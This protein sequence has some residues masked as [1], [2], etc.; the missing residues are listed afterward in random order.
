MT[1][2]IR[3]GLFRVDF[4]LNSDRIAHVVYVTADRGDSEPTWIEF[5]RSIE[6]SPEVVWPDSPPLQELHVEARDERSVALLVGRAGKSHWS[7]S[8][9]SEAATV[10]SDDAADVLVFD[11]ACRVSGLPEMLGSTYELAEGVSWREN[12]SSNGRGT[13][14]S[15]ALM[16]GMSSE[17]RLDIDAPGIVSLEQNAG[18]MRIQAPTAELTLPATVRW[19]FTLA[20]LPA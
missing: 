13:G 16:V 19:R 6:S 4:L 8:I 18:R 15:I 2:T 3:S 11:I 9:G 14:C 5:M 20:H 1:R 17:W 12:G 10:G 7:A